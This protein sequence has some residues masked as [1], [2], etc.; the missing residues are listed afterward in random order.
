MKTTNTSNAA[1]VALH[2]SKE[3]QNS[4]SQKVTEELMELFW[5]DKTKGNVHWILTSNNQLD[6]KKEVIKMEKQLGIMF[7]DILWNEYDNNI[8]E[9]NKKHPLTL[10][11]VMEDYEE[12]EQ[13]A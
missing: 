8:E 2:W 7:K 10:A 1:A 6:D 12:F 11:S 3:E 13:A 4:L 5:I 9:L